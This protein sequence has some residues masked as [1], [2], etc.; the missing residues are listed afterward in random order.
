MGR[1]RNALIGDCRAEVSEEGFTEESNTRR[2][3]IKWK[4]IYRVSA[5]P[6]FVRIHASSL[7]VHLI[8]RRAFSSREDSETFL[9]IA[10]HFYDAANKKK[11]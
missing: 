11:G 8:P 7:S 4:G 1:S 2:T 10:R 3:L 5:T 6:R 9:K